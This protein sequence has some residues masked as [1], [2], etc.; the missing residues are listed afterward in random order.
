[1]IF[2][3]DIIKLICTYLSNF[4]INY[5]L[6]A[7]KSLYKL[8]NQVQF[9]N[10]HILT[11]KINK[12]PYYDSFVN[13]IISDDYCYTFPKNLQKINFNVT[14]P[15]LF[16]LMP[17]TVTSVKINNFDWSSLKKIT[18]PNIKK[19]VIDTCHFDKSFESDDIPP[20]ITCLKMNH[21]FLYGTAR[22][23]C[24]P[25]NVIYL[26]INIV[27]REGIIPPSVKYLKTSHICNDEYIPSSV[28]IIEID[29]YHE[30]DKPL[31]NA[32]HLIFSIVF[33][34]KFKIL[35]PNFT[36]VTFKK[37]HETPFDKILSSNVTHLT[38]SDTFD[39]SIIDTVPLTVKFLTI[40]KFEK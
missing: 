8:K 19:L 23:K 9:I 5:F 3:L 22:L 14:N 36:H 27:F 33:D 1:M 18:L 38:L 15:K 32:T 4:D 30:D 35:P 40:K 11:N 24:I 20:S 39:K 16:P 6:S 10:K 31:H 26:R 7:S 28:S 37:S 34:N 2:I 13:L 29:K 25:P 12:L 17:T 21:N